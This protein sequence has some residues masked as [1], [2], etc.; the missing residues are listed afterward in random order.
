[1]KMWKSCLVNCFQLP[2]ELDVHVEI[3]YV[4]LVVDGCIQSSIVCYEVGLW[5]KWCKKVTCVELSSQVPSLC[6]KINTGEKV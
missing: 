5:E 6:E 4:V 2:L 1:M 3:V